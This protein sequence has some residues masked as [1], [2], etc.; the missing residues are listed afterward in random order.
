[1][2]VPTLII[3]KG[4]EPVGKNVGYMNEQALTSFVKNHV[5]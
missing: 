2:G 5:G 4:G 1:M 3:F